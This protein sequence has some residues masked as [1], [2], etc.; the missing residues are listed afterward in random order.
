MQR[1]G[2]RLVFF[3]KQLLL[4]KK[5]CIDTLIAFFLNSDFMDIVLF[6]LWQFFLK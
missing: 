6:I 5:Y 1:F 3:F 4:H 2:V